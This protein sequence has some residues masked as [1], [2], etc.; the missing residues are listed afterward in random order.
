MR[1]ALK[2]TVL[3]N[4]LGLIMHPLTALSSEESQAARHRLVEQLDEVRQRNNVAAMG[5]VIVEGDRVTLL[6]T[7]GLHDR[8][9]GESIRD[10][11]IFRIGSISKMFTGLLAAELDYREVVDLESEIHREETRDTY[12]NPYRESHPI[13]LDQLLEQTAG[14][15]DMIKPE[16]DYSDPAQLPLAKTL[17]LYPQARVAQWPPGLHYSYTNAGAGLAG[18]SMELA[19]GKSYEALLEQFVLA[20]LGMADTSVLPPDGNRLAAGYD[21]DGSSSIPYW[22]Q[23]FRPFGAINSTLEDM[24]SS[25][26]YPASPAPALV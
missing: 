21:T 2:I 1:A 24:S 18:Y 3:A 11:A 6:K 26:K 15:T 16:W 13:R 12:R 9:S 14:F 23:I 25:R 10:D 17:R 5:L 20:P 8:V 19:T 22:H 7:L 4:L